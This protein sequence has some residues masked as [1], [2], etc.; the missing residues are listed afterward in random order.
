[1]AY[2]GV[3]LTERGRASLSSAAV[4]VPAERIAA[5][6]VSGQTEYDAALFGRL[7]A[8]RRQRADAAN[9]PAFVVF[10]DRTL[11]EM[12]TYFPQSEQSLLAIHGV[13]SRKLEQHGAA[14][15]EAIR[16]YCSE[17]GL[18]ERPRPAVAPAG[19]GTGYDGSRRR[20]E[21]KRRDVR[22]GTHGGRDRRALRR[23]PQ[24]DLRAPGSVGPGGPGAR[25][26][27]LTGRIAAFP[28]RA[29]PRAGAVSGDGLPL[30]RPQSAR[31]PATW[32]PTKSCTCSATA[33]SAAFSGRTRRALSDAA[34]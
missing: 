17:Q 14:F 23:E 8:L 7:S 16:A 1:M 6:T 4:S 31:S 30:P 21:Y 24:D 12:A 25:C 27:P 2:G 34:T 19:R 18:A 10:S 26:G 32:C 22:R 33:T 11:A 28:V 13:G 5:M 20:W 3:R 9:I 15:L 29:S